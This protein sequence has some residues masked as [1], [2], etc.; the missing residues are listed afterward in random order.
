MKDELEKM[1]IASEKLIVGNKYWFFNGRMELV[2]DTL[3]KIVN[4][5]RTGMFDTIPRKITSIYHTKEE[6]L[7][8]GEY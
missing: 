3:T 5:G 2:Y 8:I 6:A 4:D 1:R 7:A